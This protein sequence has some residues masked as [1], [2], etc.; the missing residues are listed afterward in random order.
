MAFDCDCVLPLNQKSE[1][2]VHRPTAPLSP[3]AKKHSV[4]D[5]AFPFFS[6]MFSTRRTLLQHVL[7]LNNALI[8]TMETLKLKLRYKLLQALRAFLSRSSFGACL[9]K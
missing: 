2:D 5:V 1:R 3:S 8:L 9:L 6:Y 4:P 7:L